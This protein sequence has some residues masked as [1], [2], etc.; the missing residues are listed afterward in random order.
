MTDIKKLKAL[1]EAAPTG[2]WYPPDTDS[3]K[4]MVFDCDLGSLLSYESIDTERDACVAY[5][6]AANPAAVLELIAQTEEDAMH[7]RAFGEVMR[8]QAEQIDQLKAENTD[9]H[10]TLQAAKGE[11]ERLRSANK[12]VECRFEIS[13]DTLKTIRGCLASAESDIDQLK[14][15]NEALRNDAA[16]WQFVRDVWPKVKLVPNGDWFNSC[17]LE[18]E[19][20]A[21]MSKE[22]SHD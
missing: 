9:L 16:R 15:E 11:I 10:A 17:F 19:I 7:M 13:E 18:R 14:A 2:P 4:G 12:T 5:V 21:A 1:A 22:A 20:D 6:A 8:S 3:H